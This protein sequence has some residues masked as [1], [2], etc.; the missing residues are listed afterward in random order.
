MECDLV[1]QRCVSVRHR[2]A[3][4]GAGGESVARM[5]AAW[6][7]Q[8]CAPAR[9]RHARSGSGGGVQAEGRLW[10]AV[11]RWFG[12]VHR[13]MMCLRRW[14][15]MRLSGRVFVCRLKLLNV[16]TVRASCYL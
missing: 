5:D 12:V 10:H 15:G 14:V 8:A 3:I 9:S 6:P 7:D 11:S 4:E 1:G 2:R 16:H 13:A